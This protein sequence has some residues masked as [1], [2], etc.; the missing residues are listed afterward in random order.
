[1]F[2]NMLFFRPCANVMCRS[3]CTECNT[4]TDAFVNAY[5]TR[6]EYRKG[7]SALNAKC[8]PATPFLLDF[9]HAQL[10]FNERFSAFVNS[11]Q[12]AGDEALCLC[13]ALKH[14]LPSYHCSHSSAAF[15]VATN[16]TRF[17]LREITHGPTFVM[18]ASFSLIMNSSDLSSLNSTLLFDSFFKNVSDSLMESFKHVASSRSAFALSWENEYKVHSETGHIVFTSSA[19]LVAFNF[20]SDERS[21]ISSQDTWNS[22]AISLF[23]SK[24]PSPAIRNLVSPQTLQARTMGPYLILCFGFVFFVSLFWGFPS[25][26]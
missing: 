1:M 15:V 21:I 13:F 2:L 20:S 14:V 26:L 6:S 4:R 10:L 17:I 18:P 25:F 22:L 9:P 8:S 11:N 12:P 23:H 16:D 24:T 5:S 19:F 3:C 7:A